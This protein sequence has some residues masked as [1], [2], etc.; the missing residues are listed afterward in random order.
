MALF[1]CNRCKNKDG[2]DRVFE[3]DEAYVEARSEDRDAKGVPV[4]FC[5]HCGAVRSDCEEAG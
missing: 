2:T 1:K 5:P 4:Q 3:A